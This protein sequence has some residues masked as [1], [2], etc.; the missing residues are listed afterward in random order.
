[1]SAAGASSSP[2]GAAVHPVD[3]VGRRGEALAALERALGGARSEAIEIRQRIADLGGDP[4][5][6]PNG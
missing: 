1:M 3:A 4:P 6:A 2:P 5:T